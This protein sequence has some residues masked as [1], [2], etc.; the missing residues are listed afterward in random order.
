[1]RLVKRSVTLFLL[2]AFCSPASLSADLA[3][4]FGISARAIGMGNAYTALADDYGG[5]FYNPAGLATLPR[6]ALTVGYLFTN[7][8]I[9]VQEANG[10]ERLAFTTSLKGGMIGF[11]MDV[12]SFFSEKVRRSMVMGLTA[13]FPDNFKTYVNA[14]TKFYEELQFPVFG[15]VHD[16]AVMFMGGGIELHRMLSVGASARL[17]FT[18]DI[19]DIT[20]LYHTT[21]F[22]IDYRKLDIDAD[23]EIQPIVGLMFTPLEKLRIG[24]VWRKG[25]SPVHFLGAVNVTVDTGYF[26]LPLPPVASLLYEFYTPEEIALSIAFGPYKRI[27]V[28]AEAEYAE[29]SAYDVPYAKRPPGRPMRDIVIPRVGIEYSLQKDLKVRLGYYYHPSPVRSRQPF[30]Y[31]LDTDQHVFSTG[32]GYT[33]R[34]IERFIGYPLEFDLYFQFQYLP[35]RTLETLEVPTSLWGYIVNVGGS[36]QFR[37]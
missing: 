21:N 36:V 17:A 37:F 8:R 30:T 3:D 20:I 15:R 19:R 6:D 7:P 12:G 25:G 1:V 22:Q 16:F 2:G 23:T 26:P 10:P 27:L 31:F 4:Q 13:V 11:R 29:W 34:Y 24:A 9:K 28:A 5:L 35:R 32:A 18:A 14:D 33:W